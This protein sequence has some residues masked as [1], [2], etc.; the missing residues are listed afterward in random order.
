MGLT[1]L[2]QVTPHY[3]T[4]SIVLL[5]IDHKLRFSKIVKI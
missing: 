5:Q 1:L 2:M 4:M 3:L